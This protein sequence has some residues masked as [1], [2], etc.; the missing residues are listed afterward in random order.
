MENAPTRLVAWA[1]ALL[2]ALLSCYFPHSPLGLFLE[3]TAAAIFAGL[4]I[5][6]PP[7]SAAG[8]AGP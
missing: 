6:A 3:L 1:L 7:G 2:L 5:R 8:Q 4:S